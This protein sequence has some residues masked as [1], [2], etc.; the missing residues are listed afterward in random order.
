MRRQRQSGVAAITAVMIVAVAAS[1]VSFM[2]AQESATLDQATMVVARAQADQYARAGLDW[3]RGVLAADDPGIDALTDGWAQ[4]MV[5]LPV[6]RA[7]VSGTIS[8]EQGKF[9]LDNLVVN[10]QPSADD[11]AIFRQLLA[12]LGLS[13]DLADAVVDWIDTNSTVSGNGGAEDAWYLAQPRPGR[14]ADQPMVQAEE[15]YRIRGFDPATVAKVLPYVTALYQPGTRTLI[16]INTAS[17]VVIAAA[18]PAV[19]AS[20]IA[21]MIQRRTTKPFAST[22]EVA[23]W[24][25]SLNPTAST[26][27]LGV[28][29]RFFSVHVQVAQDDVQVATDALMVRGANA[30]APG[31]TALVWRRARF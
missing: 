26:A 18:L 1:A 13:P 30:S 11:I 8:D 25:S 2:L 31:A 19:P 7:V 22:A 24:V 12:S 28:N 6:D 9:N 27:A 29:T 21:Q 10:D 4:P 20:A 3:A 17:A 16:N 23:Q 15:L 14:A 5:G